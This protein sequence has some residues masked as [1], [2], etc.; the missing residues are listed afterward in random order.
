MPFLILEN[1]FEKRE[2]AKFYSQNKKNM[3]KNRG[4]FEN[5]KI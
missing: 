3:K 2:F 5:D 1:N 4:G